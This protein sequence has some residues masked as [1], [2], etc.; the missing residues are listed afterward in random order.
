MTKKHD[1]IHL[2]VSLTI[3]LSVS[4][5]Y[6]GHPSFIY[7]VFWIGGFPANSAKVSS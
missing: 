2:S 6:N 4:T 1:A 5:L 7:V 3:S